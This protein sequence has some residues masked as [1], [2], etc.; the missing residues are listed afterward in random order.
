MAHVWENVTATKYWYREVGGSTNPFDWITGSDPS[1]WYNIYVKW[2]ELWERDPQKVRIT[3]A[4]LSQVEF[5]I[6]DDLFDVANVVFQGDEADE[7]DGYT[8]PEVS[9]F[10]V[11][12]I[13][14]YLEEAFEVVYSGIT[15]RQPSFIQEE[16]DELIM[17][18]ANMMRSV[19]A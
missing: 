15:F 11:I 14:F 18:I 7:Y 12:K 1:I 10:N 4:N 6:S 17:L 9:D 8:P 2:I 3:F 5:D 19:N 16:D 13:E